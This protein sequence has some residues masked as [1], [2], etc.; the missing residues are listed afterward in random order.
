MD[1]FGDISE[2]EIEKFRPL[3]DRSIDDVKTELQTLANNYYESIIVNDSELYNSSV[4]KLKEYLE[5][6]IVDINEYLNYCLVMAGNKI[7]KKICDVDSIYVPNPVDLQ[8]RT[9]YT[10]DNENHIK[11][12]GLDE[13]EIELLTQ[14]IKDKHNIHCLTS[15]ID[16]NLVNKLKPKTNIPQELAKTVLVNTHYIRNENIKKNGEIFYTLEKAF[17]KRKK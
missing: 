8:F 5:F 9:K 15:A 10:R 2:E 14:Y 11:R 6:D 12:Y 13:S 16:E 1:F 7:L 17:G 4:A 3:L